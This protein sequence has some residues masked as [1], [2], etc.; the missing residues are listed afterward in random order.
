MTRRGRFFL[1]IFLTIVVL[2]TSYSVN[3]SLL[4]NSYRFL[5]DSATVLITGSSIMSSGINP[6]YLNN[7]ENIA[8]AAEPFYV[9][10]YKIKDACS[11]KKNIDKVVISYS[12]PE[13]NMRKDNFFDG[14]APIT[15]E[16]FER[17]SYLDGGYSLRN[18]RAFNIDYFRYVESFIRNR[19]FPNYFYWG[20]AIKGDY[21]RC[22]APHIGDFIPT[23]STH[24]IDEVINF[25]K[26]CERFFSTNNGRCDF[27]NVDNHY[28]D[29]IVSYC[30]AKDLNLIL[31]SMP[32]RSK[33]Y[34]M[35]PSGYINYHDSVMNSLRL[36][37]NV[38]VMD[39]VHLLQNE[40]FM[41]YIHLNEH[42]ARKVTAK[43]AQVIDSL[44]T[45]IHLVLA[46]N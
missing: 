45:K 8:H 11:Q 40:Y 18:F 3:K 13:L 35:I 20:H 31:I 33:L 1:I 37:S 43:L 22:E 34:E 25:E 44:D 17:M 23:G 2:F 4:R 39:E 24:Q 21:N 41:D 29:S 7:A 28:I 38:T 14:D 42:G 10:Y 27:A 30:N 36:Q 9:S 26:W 19:V 5:S 6:V 15:I 32:V 12:L 16:L 46:Q